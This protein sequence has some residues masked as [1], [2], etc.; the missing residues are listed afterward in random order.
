MTEV[1]NYLSL[2]QL[3]DLTLDELDVLPLELAMIDEPLTILI[4]LPRTEAKITVSPRGIGIV[5]K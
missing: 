2:D 1:L 4:I 3:D 5:I